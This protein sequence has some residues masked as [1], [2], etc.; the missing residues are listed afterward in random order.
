VKVGDLVKYRAD[1]RMPPLVGMVVEIASGNDRRVE[2]LGV[3]HQTWVSQE[4]LEK[5]S[6]SR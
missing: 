4:N 5:V 3:E 2:W 6:E 1:A